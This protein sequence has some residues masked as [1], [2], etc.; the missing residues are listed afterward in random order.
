M[1][2]VVQRFL[3][4][5]FITLAIA[6]PILALVFFLDM[7]QHPEYALLAYIAGFVSAIVILAALNF[8][9]Y[10]KP[11][12]WHSE[13]K[14]GKA[15]QALLAL[16]PSGIATV[17]ALSVAIFYW[18][19]TRPIYLACEITRSTEKEDVGGS[20]I[21]R[22][23]GVAGSLS[24]DNWDYLMFKGYGWQSSE[25]RWRYG[26][27]LGIDVLSADN[28]WINPRRGGYAAASQEFNSPGIHGLSVRKDEFEVTDYFGFSDKPYSLLKISR[29]TGKF[30]GSDGYKSATEGICKKVPPPVS[31]RKPDVT[32]KF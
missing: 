4:L 25:S 19:D 24:P 1:T 7:P 9:L 30:V 22:I 13:S 26:S 3:N 16:I 14:G 15:G 5:A 23:H 28:A 12:I 10:R 21:Y 31:E 17:Y 2:T 32:V 18:A 11:T 8:V 20:Y 29:S 27:R 6:P